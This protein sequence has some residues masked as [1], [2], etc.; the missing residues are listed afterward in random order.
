MRLAPWV[1]IFQTFV[2]FDSGDKMRR[3]QHTPN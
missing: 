3:W 1:K 2:F